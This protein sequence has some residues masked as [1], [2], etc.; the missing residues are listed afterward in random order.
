MSFVNDPSIPAPTTLQLTIVNLTITSANQEKG[1][2]SSQNTNN[3]SYAR[4]NHNFAYTK[5]L[6]RKFYK[7]LL[8]YELR[9]LLYQQYKPSIDF[10]LNQ[11][12][13][14]TKEIYEMDN[15]I[16][17]AIIS[18]LISAGAYT[19][20]GLARYTKLPIEILIETACG[21]TNNLSFTLWSRVLELY[22]HL[23][24][25]LTRLLYQRLYVLKEDPNFSL[26]AILNEED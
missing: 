21:K 12:L 7:A 8:V 3:S 22:L 4:N 5:K 17:Q 24:P 26:T 2:Q 1:M 18:E 15:R 19:F 25:E 10:Q 20:E 6:E 14:S 11:H 16:L 9:N 23:K 13:D